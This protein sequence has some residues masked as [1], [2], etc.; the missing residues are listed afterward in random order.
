MEQWAAAIATLFLRTAH[1]GLAGP[2]DIGTEFIKQVVTESYKVWLSHA[3]AREGLL[4]AR[5]GPRGTMEWAL[6]S[7]NCTNHRSGTAL[8]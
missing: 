8:N 7:C 6:Q 4:K 1:L 5:A 2:H 3:K